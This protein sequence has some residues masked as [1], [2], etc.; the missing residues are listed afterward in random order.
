MINCKTKFIPTYAIIVTAGVNVLLIAL[1]FMS[2][3]LLADK[4]KSTVAPKGYVYAR[5]RKRE[6]YPTFGYMKHMLFSRLSQPFK[7]SRID[8]QYE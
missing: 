7:G 2:M 8:M 1:L 5:L 4:K 3:A 6:L